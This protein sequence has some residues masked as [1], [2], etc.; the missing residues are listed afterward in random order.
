MKKEK[1]QEEELMGQLREKGVRGVG[2]VK[3]CYLEGNGSIS[4]IQRSSRES[5]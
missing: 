5:H 1:I 2:E 4:V 3:E